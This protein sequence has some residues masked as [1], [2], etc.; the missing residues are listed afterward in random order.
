[1]FSNLKVEMSVHKMYCMLYC[2]LFSS[3]ASVVYH[4]LS[5]IEVYMERS[6]LS[7]HVDFKTLELGNG[8]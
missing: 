6:S 5:L 1:M 2:L 7:I 4:D 8:C 3:L